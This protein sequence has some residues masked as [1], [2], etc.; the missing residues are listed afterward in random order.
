MKKLLFILLILGT[1]TFTNAQT[2]PVRGTITDAQG[3]PME[4]VSIFVK[5]NP[6][7]KV[8]SNA[9][10]IFQINLLDFDKGVLVFSFV[11]Y[12][13]QEVIVKNRPVI[14]IALK[15]NPAELNEV[16]VVAALGITRKQKSVT[17]ASQTVD[18]TTLTEARD[19]NF[20]NGLTGK[21]AGLQVTG[22]GQPGSSVR[23]TLRGDNS[24]SGNNQPLMVIDGVPVD[25]PIG[26]NGN[27]DY[28][29]PI[30][31]INPDDIESITVLKGPNGAA[32]Y[33][34]KA[35]N[36]AILITL[37]KGKTG[38]DG[39]LGIDFNQSVQG[40]K[41]TAF[42]D[43]QNVY[44]EGSGMRLAQN[45]GNTIN[46]NNGGVNM[47]SF[48]QSWGAP[49]LGQPYNSFS[50][51]PIPEG[52]VPQSN[53][54]SDLYQTGFTSSSN[55]SISKSD[56]NS[57]FRLSYGFTNGNDVVQNVNLIKKHNLSISA[58]R[59]LGKIF[60]VET[61]VNYTNWNTKNRMLKNL[62]PGNPLAAYVYMARS[63]RLDAFLPFRDE[64]GNSPIT[65][66]V[67][68]TENPYWSINANSNED[69]RSAINGA[70]VAT[71]NITTGLKLRGQVVA[72]MSTV[73]N[74]VHKELGGRLVP[75]GSYSNLLSRQ[76]NMFY[77]LLALYTK[78]LG[79]DFNVE[80]LA[81]FSINDV[82]IIARAASIS[83][84]LVQNMPS[85]GNANSVPTASE[86]LT[87]S[88]Q[89]SAYVKATI[90]YKEFLYLDVS[91]RQEW[92]STLPLSNNTFFYP[93]I[94]ANV[95]FS[96][97][98]NN[99]NII[100]SG[101]LR[102]NYARV[103]NSTS[104][105]QL[106]NTYNTLGLFLGSPL[107]SY[108]NQL[109]NPDLKPEQQISKEIGLELALF[110]NAIDFS[111]TYYNNSTIN[112]IVNIQTPSETGYNN[113][114]VNAGE[115]QN[116]GFELTANATIIK[117]KN[118]TWKAGLNFSKNL[119]EVVSILPNVSRIILGSRLTTFSVNAMV[120]QPF[121]VHLGS[122]PYMI[123]DT[124]LVASATGR[125]IVNPNQITG[126]P[127]PDWIG[128]ISNSI[129]YKGFNLQVTATVKM[130]GVI[131]SES[132]GRAV[133]QGN[134]LT[135]LVGRDAFFLSN[136]ILG[137]ND[138]ER[139]NI[140]QTVGSN[141]TR[142]LD[143]NRVKGAVYPNAY[144]PRTGPGGVLLTDAKGNPLVG[145]KF[146]GWM[147]PTTYA[148]DNV[149]SNVPGNTFDA[150]SIRISEIILG[151]TFNKNIFGKK[152]FVKGA[153][154]ALTGR[155]I[156][157]IYQKT[158]L[159][160]DPESVTGAGNATMGVESGGSFPYA[161]FGASIK[162]SF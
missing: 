64:F 83:A 86:S 42:P 90:G 154:V 32:L 15:I 135:S 44:G 12:E 134:T 39:T 36:G 139:R 125:D 24:F 26:T 155:N 149:I 69:T 133:F 102:V 53:N 20:L 113:R 3:I 159:G 22:T 7:N 101:K 146:L 54:V 61:R 72:D 30:S 103:G 128:G 117:K 142:Y 71:A 17:Y 147:N 88:R 50:G 51:V 162:L 9:K 23:L 1:S 57:A 68:N 129:S 49:M 121:G 97:F 60:K 122:V 37:K 43:Y 16:V 4:G 19:L 130:G 35:A 70:I 114:I 153:Y 55:L 40:Y 45:N 158:P 56:A 85:I 124:T 138:N 13:N 106:I 111:A 156:W 98:I 112:Q 28:G 18:P 75:L 148:S 152:S 34:A 59:N 104:P 25:N 123:G 100:S 41:V 87:R 77:E 38:G 6:S 67:N 160:I 120:G 21:V 52:Y 80:T 150:T 116:K 141:I 140:G 74:Y 14:N 126:S 107:L 131:F 89:Q 93:G 151:Y 66:Q 79:N 63:T 81:G 143:S 8:L 136:F 2:K 110:K 27:L 99:K 91:G 161:T 10:G 84:L 92:S 94:G 145:N 48:N 118:F 76:N 144:I 105:Y 137:E 29:N 157:Q 82:N 65:N 58:T 33:G 47:G 108:T 115:I 46:R 119:N 31:N 132:Y 127:R 73:D 96:Q 11:G 62:D 5:S 78:K 109:K 95:N